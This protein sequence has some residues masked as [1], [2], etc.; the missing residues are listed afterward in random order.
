MRN[1]SDHNVWLELERQKYDGDIP[2]DQLC[3]YI[4]TGKIMNRPEILYAIAV[5]TRQNEDE[6]RS[7]ETNVITVI[8]QYVPFSNV[9]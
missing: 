9:L 5:A 8:K 6:S 1:C 4:F 2:C 7:C 3:V